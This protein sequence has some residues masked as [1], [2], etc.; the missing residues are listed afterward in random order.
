MPNLGVARRALHGDVDTFPVS[1]PSPQTSCH[2]LSDVVASD[3]AEGDRLGM[4]LE[5][6]YS[7]YFDPFEP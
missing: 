2:L 7:L 3:R 6:A 4:S 1:N 5:N